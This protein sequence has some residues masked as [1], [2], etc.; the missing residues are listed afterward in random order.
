[1]VPGENVQVRCKVKNAYA[2]PGGEIYGMHVKQINT[3]S[4]PTKGLAAFYDVSHPVEVGYGGSTPSPVATAAGPDTPT[5]SNGVP[6]SLIGSNVTEIRYWCTVAG[7]SGGAVVLSQQLIED[8]FQGS[9][10]ATT[11]LMAEQ[12]L[13]PPTNPDDPDSW[14]EAG[15]DYHYTRLPQPNENGWNTTPV[16]V[17][18]FAGDFNQ[19]ALTPANG[20]AAVTL[21][22]QQVWTRSDDTD[23]YDVE[24]RATNTTSGEVSSKKTG[25]IK[26]DTWAPRIERDAALEAYTLTDVPSDPSK[27]T[28]GIWRLYRTG[29]SGAVASGARAGVYRPFD[30]TDGDGKP[31]QAVGKLPNGWY[32]AEDAAGN[33]SAPLKVSSTEPPAVERPAGSVLGPSDPGYAPPVGPEL[34]P[35]ADPVPAPKVTEDDE[36]LRHAVIE[37]SVSEMIDPASPPF[38]GLLEKSEASAMMDYRY[39][40]TSAAAPVSVSDE[41]L[42]AAGN[43]I[44]SFDTKS[45]GECL[46]RRV[47]A[48]SQGNTTTILLHYAT[49]RDNC[50][51]VRPIVPVDPN[52]PD[53]PTEPGDPVSPSGPVTTDPDGTQHATVDCEATEAT[54]PGTMDQVGALALLERHFNVATLDDARVHLTVQSMKELAGGD[55]SSIDLSRPADYLITYLAADDEGNTTTVRLTYHLVKSKAPE[56]KPRPTPTD[57]DPAPLE[58]SDPPHIHPDGTHHAVMSDKMR[59]PAQAGATLSLQAARELMEGRYT[60]AALGGGAT[61]ERS[62]TMATASGDP[63]GSI[64]LS[65]P[66]AYLIS[67]MRADADG[68]TSTVNLTY[69]VFRDEC[70][71]IRPLEPTDPADPTGPKQPGEPIEPSG[72]VTEG[73]DGAQS[74]EVECEVTEAV[75]HGTMGAAGAE[76]LLRRHFLPTD[77]DGGSGVTVTVQSMKNAAGNQLSA[78]D[79]SRAADYLITYLVRDAAGNSTTVRLTYHLVSSRVPGTIVTPDPGTDPNPQPG[80]DPLNPK[81]RPIDPSYPPTVAPDGTQHADIEDAMY[82]KVQPG[83]SLTMADAR[84]L[85]LRRYTFT[86]EGGGAMKELA[87]ALADGTGATVSSIDLS[88]PGSWRITWKVADQNGNTVT[89]RLRYVVT[90]SSPSVTPSQPGGSEGPGG[91]DPG[92]PGGTPS[93]TPLEPSE[94]T[95]DPDTGLAHSVVEDHVIVST[96][97]ER[98][99]PEAMSAFIASRYAFAADDGTASKARSAVTR[100]EVHLF[101]AYRKAVSAIDRSAPSLWYADQ[102]IADAWGNTTTLRLTYEVRESTAGGSMD[103]TGNGSGDGSGAGNGGNGSG[104]GNGSDDGSGRGSGW[105]SRIHELPQTGGIL[106]P[107]P[108][109]PLFALMILLTSA[110]TMMRLRQEARAHGENDARRKWER[111]CS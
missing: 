109:H 62:L 13:R 32:V 105:A 5:G 11:E 68:N 87:L 33:L 80:D 40:A 70:P 1:M 104:A 45:P 79:T 86:P 6:I 100:G 98:V 108:L 9:Q 38:G 4:Y 67:Y 47:I 72:P 83:G 88:R 75:C 103:G 28:S 18:F 12:S 23:G 15:H 22:D 107:C 53:G 34:G 64:D 101:D 20:D 84:S 39:A 61:T 52:D 16:S 81:P 17:Q 56:V 41:L 57:P 58:P 65:K 102:T 14:G 66:G 91:T 97:D 85:M 37:E 44:A 26:I 55:V 59:V 50:P 110:Y 74:V 46:I 19:L 31:T 42:D 10:Y 29:S 92:N 35:G 99:T 51:L 7:V 95:V 36:G 111:S 60:F 8:T 54:G 106:G 78:I 30:L 24:I 71:V 2:S 73:P 49:I 82:V 27:A 21:S 90:S 77:V 94:V 25:T 96:A 3:S 69:E 76:A 43:A 93:G 48:D 63:V 89:I